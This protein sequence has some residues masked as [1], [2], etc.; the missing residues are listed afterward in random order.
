MATEQ[1]YVDGS[2]LA[3]LLATN[4]QDP[5]PGDAPTPASS[6]ETLPV[7]SNWEEVGSGEKRRKRGLAMSDICHVLYEMTDGWPRRVDKMLFAPGAEF[8]PRFLENAAQLFAWIDHQAVADWGKASDMISMEWFMAHL[9]ETALRYD[10]VERFPHWPPL[11]QT[12]YLHPL[13]PS[14]D[15]HYLEAFLDFFSPYTSIDRQLIRAFIASLLW[16]GPP[17]SR[18]AWL[19]TAPDE[20]PEGGRGVGKSKIIEFCAELVGGMMEISPKEDIIGIKK[21]LLSPAAR[22]LRVA[23]LD[24]IKTYRF[25]WAD[26][27]GL[28]TSPWISGHRMYRGEGRRPNTITWTLTLNGASLSKD[29]AQRVIVVKL[30]RPSYLATWEQDVRTFIEHYRWH[31]LSDVR[32]MLQ[33]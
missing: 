21:R 28:I 15:G 8:E 31:I 17:G 25:S 3:E 27:E 10:S 1:T 7:F 29:L 16:G 23:R 14:T 33:T 32:L 30:Q 24:N 13:L 20:D 9:E 18:P 6:G 22:T 19:F 5:E 11:P 2:V 4:A 26:L 12:F